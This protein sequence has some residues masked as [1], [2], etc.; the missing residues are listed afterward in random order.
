MEVKSSIGSLESNTHPRARQQQ[1]TSKCTF[2]P[3]VVSRC[4][5][6]QL[7]APARSTRAHNA[8]TIQ[9]CTTVNAE[10]NAGNSFL[11]SVSMSNTRSYIATWIFRSSLRSPTVLLL[12][13]RPWSCRM[14]LHAPNRY[15]SPMMN[16]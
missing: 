8:P 15:T 13:S 16:W 3:A 10:R 12:N 2:N 6:N 9:D 11:S 14:M 4:S 1:K 5:I 7:L